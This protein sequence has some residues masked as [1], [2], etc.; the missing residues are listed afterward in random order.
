MTLSFQ[1]LVPIYDKDYNDRASD[2]SY[3]NNFDQTKLQYSEGGQTEGV[4]Y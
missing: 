4:G 3:T 2:G 1:E